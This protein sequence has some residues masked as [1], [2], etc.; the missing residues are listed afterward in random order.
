GSWCLP[1][2]YLEENYCRNPDGDPR[3]WCFTTSSTKRWDFCSIPRCGEGIA[4]RGTVAVTESG[5]TCQSWSSQTP[6]KHNRTP[7]NY[8]C[9]GLDNNYCRNPDNERQPWC[10]TTDPETRWE[11]CSVPKCSNASGPSDEAVIP[12]DEEDCYEGD[13]S[14]YRGVTSETISGKKCQAWSSMS[15]H[16]H[17]KTPQTFPNA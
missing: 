10:Y 3:P 13:G 15:P 11:Y 7:D 12:P 9:K 2:K 17:Q 4:Y 1:D 6:H 5:K 16:V 8:P 14:S